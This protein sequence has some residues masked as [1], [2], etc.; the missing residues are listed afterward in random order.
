MSYS[1]QVQSE[2]VFDIK[3]AFE[4]YEEQRQ[5]L[6]EELL[7]EIESCFDK[8]VNHPFHYTAIN[9][10]FRRIKVNRFP[11]LV[12]YEVEQSIIIINSV[13]HT[14]RKPRY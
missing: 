2:A 1:L 12:V 6:G 14:S 4:W 9:P 8:L 13:E 7:E 3:E 5:G 11:Y 10:R